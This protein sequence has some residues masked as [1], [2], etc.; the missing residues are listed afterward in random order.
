MRKAKYDKS[1]SI[2]LPREI[3]EEIRTIT[4]N[5]EISI[6]EWFRHAAQS[7]LNAPFIKDTDDRP[8]SQSV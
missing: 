3:Y 7:F 5:H 1:L 4:D 6:S 2:T 8:R